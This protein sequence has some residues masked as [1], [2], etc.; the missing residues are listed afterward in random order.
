[1]SHEI[2]SIPTSLCYMNGDIRKINKSSSLKVLETESV[3]CNNFPQSSEELACAIIDVMTIG[4]IIKRG[5]HKAFLEI[6]PKIIQNMLT[7]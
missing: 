3:S 5:N 6:A 4:Q 7:L 1:M 2:S